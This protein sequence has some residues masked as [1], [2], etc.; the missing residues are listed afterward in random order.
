NSGIVL[1]RL[2]GAGDWKAHAALLPLAFLGGLSIPVLIEMGEGMFHWRGLSKH[3][4]AV[5][6]LSAALY[7]VGL[8]VLFPFRAAAGDE[9]TRV[10][11]S[12]ALSL[13]ARSAGLPF[14]AVGSL[15]RVAQWLLIVFMLI[16]VAPAGTGGGVKVTSLFHLW[17]G[18]RRA[19]RGERGLRITG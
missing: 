1:G 3:A 8:I 18:T 11:L 5:L 13:A 14:A 19:L 9:A 17:R 12:A 7:L 10:A 16:G 6:S 2:P 15:S 4:M